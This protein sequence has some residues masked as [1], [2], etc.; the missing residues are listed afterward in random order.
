VEINI[1]AVREKELHAAKGVFG[2][3]F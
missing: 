1:K 2:P 3:G